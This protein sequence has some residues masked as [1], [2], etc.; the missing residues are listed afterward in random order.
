MAINDRRK[1]DDGSRNM[2]RRSYDRLAHKAD[3]MPISQVPGMIQVA[4]IELTNDQIKALPTTSQIVIAAP[5]E[6]KA[7]A[8]LD[9]FLSKREWA[10]EYGNVDAA[11]ALNVQPYAI[12][13]VSLLDLEVV[14]ALFGHLLGGSGFSSDLADFENVA[15]T[16]EADNAAAGD[17][18]G[19]APGNKLKFHVVYAI[20]DV[21]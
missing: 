8:V 12:A 11:L 5:G 10:T 3:Y 13:F 14:D 1:T 18:T 4:T 16:I 20:V 7:I 2:G 9:A 17:F 21:R 15:V 6:G 19:G